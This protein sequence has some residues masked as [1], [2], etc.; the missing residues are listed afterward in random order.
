MTD[1]RRAH[2]A[3]ATWFFTVNLAERR[4]NRMLLDHVDLLR[5]VFRD[6]RDRHPFA[7]DAMV[8]LPEHLQCIWTLPGGDSDFHAHV[9]RGPSTRRIGRVIPM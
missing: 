8:V 9:R 7:I 2:V 5:R 6:V 4:E 1:Y 3:G